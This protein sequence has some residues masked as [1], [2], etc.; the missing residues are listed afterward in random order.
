MVEY[1]DDERLGQGAALQKKSAVC[2]LI[3]YLHVTS[4]GS[5]CGLAVLQLN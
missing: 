4:A 5:P 1:T 3:V 2:K